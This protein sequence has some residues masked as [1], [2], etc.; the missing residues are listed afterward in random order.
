VWALVY[1]LPQ[2]HPRLSKEEKQ[3]IL[4]DARSEEG[5]PTPVS[6]GYLLSRREAWGCILA[7]VL[8]DPISYF[9]FFW[10]PKYFQQERGFDLAQVGLFVWIP[11]VALTLG[12]L[13]SGAIPRYLISRGWPLSRARKTTMLAVS[14]SMPVFC[15]LVT[16]VSDPALAI[17]LMTAIMFGHAAWGNITLPAEVF[18]KHVVGTISGFGGALGAAVGAITQWNI[19][20]VVETFSFA[21]IFAVCAVMYLIALGLVHWL[22]GELGTIRKMASAPTV[23]SAV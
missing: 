22:I 15:L 20:K 6:I 21:P 1:R 16:R 23:Q 9:L 13:S 7:R 14:A 4:A 19:G 3:L 10:T 8:T 11:F 18:P 5:E 17:A 12:N 2:D